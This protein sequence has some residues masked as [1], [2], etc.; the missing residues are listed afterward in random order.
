MSTAI[1][2]NAVK[3]FGTEQYAFRRIPLMIGIVLVGVGLIALS[4]NTDGREL[5]GLVLGSAV[6][7]FGAFGIARAWYRRARPSKPALELSPQGI[8]LR[9]KQDKEF[10]IP[11]GEV[12]DL[13]QA[14]IK[15]KGF[16]YRDVT[17][18]RVSQFFFDAN[19]PLNSSYARSSLWR[20]FFL[21]KGDLVQVALHHDILSVSA[22]ALWAE[23]DARWRAFRGEPRMFGRP[24][25]WGEPKLGQDSV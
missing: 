6:A 9:I 2:V 15:G 8:L 25:R 20:Y 4:L 1:D 24:H 18:A 12:Q 17:V 13:G 14:D 16:L 11:W 5:E 23:I 19:V 7:L 21:S 22:D 3:T 10:R